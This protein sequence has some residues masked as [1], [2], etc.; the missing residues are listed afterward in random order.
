MVLR[1]EQP[2]QDRRLP[3]VVTHS[4]PQQASAWSRVGIRAT[5]LWGRYRLG[6]RRVVLLR[7]ETA[8][9]TVR[10]TKGWK[11]CCGPLPER[12]RPRSWTLKRCCGKRMGPQKRAVPR[13][14]MRGGWKGVHPGRS[15]KNTSAMSGSFKY[16]HHVERRV[17]FYSPREESFPVPL[18]YIDV[19]RTTRTNLDVMQERCIDDYWNI[20]GSRDL[21]D[22]WTGFTQFLLHW[23][24]NFQTEICGPG[25]GLTKRQATSRPDH[26]WPELSIK[27]GSNAN[28]KERETQKVRWKIKTR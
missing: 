15:P 7:T 17:K 25:G 22:S 8:Q 27:M 16:H 6:H 19:S 5:W 10:P 4:R 12:C 28:L 20:D 9:C 11:V 21:S 1:K 24:K 14:A 3:S 18:K 26:Q 23:K 13:P 2:G